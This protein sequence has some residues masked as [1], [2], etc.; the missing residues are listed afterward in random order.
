M[1]PYITGLVRIKSNLTLEEVG[2]ILS[3]ELFGD[4]KFGGRDKSI[5]E[6]IPAIF[7]EPTI[8]G[9][10]IILDGYNEEDED[11]TFLLSILPLRSS[12][13]K[14]E[15][16]RVNEYLTSLVKYLLRERSD[17]TVLEE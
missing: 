17:L 10:Q 2:A 4:L 16:F 8:L 1:I 7:I 9:S 14:S 13:L 11:Q 6:E 12:D 3:R 5:H 15:K